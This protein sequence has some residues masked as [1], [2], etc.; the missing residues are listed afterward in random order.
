MT[1]R[2]YGESDW[3]SLPRAMR[4]DDR[5]THADIHLLVAIASFDMK[6]GEIFPPQWQLAILTKMDET[7]I[8]R[9]ADNL[10]ELGWLSIVKRPGRVNHYTLKIPEYAR[11]RQKV[12]AEAIRLEIEARYEMKKKKRSVWASAKLAKSF[13]STESVVGDVEPCTEQLAEA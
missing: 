9:R 7:N 5:L 2:W 8:G 11:T 13:E 12:V 10:A 1:A 3:F 4:Y 6:G